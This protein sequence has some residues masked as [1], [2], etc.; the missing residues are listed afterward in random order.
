MGWCN[1]SMPDAPHLFVAESLS[2]FP[3]RS[4]IAML[5]DASLIY[6]IDT[7]FQALGRHPDTESVFSPWSQ[8]DP[9]HDASPYAPGV[10]VDN[11][12]RY[13]EV[14]AGVSRYLL[15][16]EAPGYQGAKFSGIAMTSERII[17]SSGDLD[18][19]VFAGPKRLT[20]RN[21]QGM[22]EPT[23]TIAWKA[24]ADSG[25]GFHQFAIWNA[26]P[27]HP[28]L[29]GAPLTNRTPSDAEM[30]L[31]LD[32]LSCFIA[33]FPYSTIAAVGRRAESSLRTLGLPFVSLRHPANGGASLFRSQ[34]SA[35]F[36]PN[37]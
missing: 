29:P 19:M 7:F 30:S 17:L 8:H 4:I 37:S 11:L 12:V 32:C 31:G 26:F 18:D 10:R 16:G 22:S 27:W 6:R 28:H 20:S 9:A 2:T 5:N 15:I 34:F 33:L 21:P 35:A 36:S 25:L 23:A 14:R 24:I 1:R 3:P 13:I